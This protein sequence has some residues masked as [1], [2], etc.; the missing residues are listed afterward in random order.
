LDLVYYSIVNEQHVLC[1]DVVFI[2]TLE[3]GYTLKFNN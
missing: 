3:F 1:K 2:C